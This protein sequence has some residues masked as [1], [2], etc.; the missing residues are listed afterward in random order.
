MLVE[1]MVS[2]RRR[3]PCQ[4]C[5]WWKRKATPSKLFHVLGLIFNLWRL[6]FFKYIFKA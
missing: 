2:Q 1:P 5:M 3:Q 6:C 4:L